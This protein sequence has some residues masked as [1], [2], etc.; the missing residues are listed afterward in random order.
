MPVACHLRFFRKTAYFDLRPENPD[1]MSSCPNCE[2]PL[3][4]DFKICPNC[5]QTTH[6]HRF[7]LAHIFHEIFHAITHTD[8]GILYLIKHMTLW[9]GVAAREYVLEYKRKRYFN[10]FTFLVLILGLAVFANSIIHPYTKRVQDLSNQF[11]TQ[12]K[13]KTYT[14]LRQRQTEAARFVESRNNLVTFAALPIIAL[15][16]WLFFRKTGINYAEHLVANIFFA[17][18]Y[19]LL[20]IL[21]SLILM[22]VPTKAPYI[23]NVIQLFI[24]VFYLTLSYYGFLNYRAPRKYALTG[25]ASLLAIGAWFVTSALVMSVYIFLAFV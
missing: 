15:V 9:P 8:K 22:A 6:L 7:T 14:I 25:A 11:K 10:P 13:K 4:A 17:A 5:G 20:S 21:I 16:F 23:L 2:A 12:E 24:H 1:R 18:Y 19:S 3:R